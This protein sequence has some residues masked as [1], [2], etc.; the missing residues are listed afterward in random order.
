MSTAPRLVKNTLYL[1]VASIG[2]KVIAFIYFTI[3]ARYL[4]VES[5]GAYFLALA[6]VTVIAVLDDVGITSIVIREI[7][8]KTQDVLVWSRT[9]IG[10]KLI[11]MPLTVLI[12]FFVPVFLGYD[13]EIIDLVRIAVVVM[14]AD[15]ISLSFY[16]LLRGLQNLTYESVGIFVGQILTA[17]IGIALMATGVA[18]LPLLIVALMIGSIWNM[19]FSVSQVVKRLGWK[20]L[21][22]TWQLGW[23]PLKMASAFF[24]AAV[25][26]KVYSYVDSIILSLQIGNEAVGI[27]AVAYKLTYAFQFLPL[28]FIAALYPTMSAQAHDPNRLKKMLLD[29]FWYMALLVAPIVFGIWSLAPEII[30]AFYGSEYSA[31]ILPLQFLIFVLIFIF[32]DF[33][34]GSLLNATGRQAIKTGIMGLVMVINVTAN[35]FLIPAFGV[36]GATYAALISFAFLFFAGW[37]FTKKV[38]KVTIV[39]LLRRISGVFFAAIVMAAAVMLVKPFVHFVL[40]IPLGVIVYVAVAFAVRAV[41]LEHL[42]AFRRLLRGLPQNKLL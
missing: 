26:V 13:Q 22:P 21:V 12:A 35:F 39:D 7:A 11:T 20:A 28:A 2:Q 8:K 27:Y 32:L 29:G 41:T 37:Y 1:T 36:V 42:R 40:V 3:I 30:I 4:G 9:I 10:V 15:T 6:I 14:L 34:I 19:I 25:F 24:L 33:P 38:V 23:K 17:S 31:S 18:P 16:G 5:T